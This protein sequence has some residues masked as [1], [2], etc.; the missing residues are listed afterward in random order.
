M[1]TFTTFIIYCNFT[2]IKCYIIIMWVVAFELWMYFLKNF[3]CEAGQKYTKNFIYRPSIKITFQ[4]S[5]I[6]T[7]PGTLIAWIQYSQYVSYVENWK[8]NNNNACFNAF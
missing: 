8:N 7:S 2:N 4:T 5:A 1:L 6:F 3:V